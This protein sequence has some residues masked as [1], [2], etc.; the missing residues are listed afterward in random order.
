MANPILVTLS[1][2]GP[3]RA[4][5]LD[6]MSGKSVLDSVNVS[7]TSMT[8]AYTIQTTLDDLQTVSSPV[9]AD[10]SS[11]L[12]GTSSNFSL[13]PAPAGIRINSTAIS[14]SFLTLRAVQGIG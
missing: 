8:A 9:W 6:S 12:S 10:A 2:V 5:N 4:C 14:S 11:A 13:T 7:S 3:S 1:S